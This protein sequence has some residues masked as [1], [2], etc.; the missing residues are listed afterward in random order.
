MSADR[1]DEMDCERLDELAGSAALGALDPDEAAAAAHHLATCAQPHAE[2]REFL[3]SDTVL[4]LAPEPAMPDPALRARVMT[5]VAATRQDH[6]APAVRSGPGSP[7]TRRSWFDWSSVGLWRGL[8][9]AAAV[10]I[11]ALGAWN[12]GL[13]Q[14]I[15]V[16]EA[17]LATIAD[18]VIGGQPAYSVT[19]QAGS[20]YVI[21]RDGPGA[22]FLVAGLAELPAGEIYELWLL[23]AAGTALAVGT[24]EVADPGLAVVALEQDLTGFALFAVTVEEERVDAPSGDPVMI[25][26]IRN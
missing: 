16:Q 13:R 19:G 5:S 2:L 14:Q 11:I 6:R 24:I 18:V 17:A 26:A 20:G 12:I 23:D 9:A 10:L 4:A 1:P 8:A 15:A 21:D 25:G 22:T 7:A 3:G